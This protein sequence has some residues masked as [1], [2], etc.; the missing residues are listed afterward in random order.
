MFIL[1]MIKVLL[2]IEYRRPD[3][4]MI[5]C[6]INN[7]TLIYHPSY[8]SVYQYEP[9]KWELYQDTFFFGWNQTKK[10]SE[11]SVNVTHSIIK[12]WKIYIA[13]DIIEKGMGVVGLLI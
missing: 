7:N 10:T 12:I 3:A 9:K 6:Y 2:K 1:K 13:H 4:I 11:T 8:S 5:L